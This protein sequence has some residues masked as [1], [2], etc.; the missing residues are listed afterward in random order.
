MQKKLYFKDNMDNHET[1]D[2]DFEYNLRQIEQMILKSS[3]EKI[4]NKF[5]PNVLECLK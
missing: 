1:K 3:E 2:T 4:N 5:S